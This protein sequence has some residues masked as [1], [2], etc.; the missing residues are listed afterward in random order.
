MLENKTLKS[1]K[2][3]LFWDILLVRENGEWLGVRAPWDLLQRVA[4]YFAVL[5][6][7]SVLS[8]T[9]WISSRW[10][11]QK[12]RDNL[13]QE[14]L[15]SASLE[16]QVHELKK[17][18]VSSGVTPGASVT[19]SQV[20]F[21]PSLDKDD[22]TAGVLKIASFEAEYDPK[23]VDFS[24]K[25]DLQREDNSPRDGNFY[26]VA[27]LH[28]NAGILSFPPALNGQNGE[29]VMPHRGQA[30]EAMQNKRSVLAR[31]KVKNF[32][33]DAGVNPVYVTLN[34][35][36]SKGSLL[37]RRRTDISLKRARMN[38]EGNMR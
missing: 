26:W 33:E 13:A 2:R 21:L 28:S 1:N 38:Q 12:L 15:K 23:T 27:L 9:G 25:F 11:S 8:I 3:S 10:M 36:D 37:L 18:L 29:V 4:T 5:L 34:V 30:I 31:Y 35:Y 16:I 19:S 22:F 24:V 14:T 7:L 17:K 20:S 6:L 32:I